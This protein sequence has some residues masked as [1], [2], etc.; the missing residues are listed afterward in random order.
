MKRTLFRTSLALILALV[1]TFT[2]I[3]PASAAPSRKPGT[4]KYL[5]E[6]AL[7]EAKDQAEAEKAAQQAQG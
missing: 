1:M 4:V 7:I 2:G 6:V 5:S 3:I